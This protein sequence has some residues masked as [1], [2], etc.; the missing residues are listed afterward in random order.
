[1]TPRRDGAQAVTRPDGSGGGP[2]AGVARGPLAGVR[3]I[4]L[5]GIG[6]GPFAASILGD[7]GADVVRIDRPEGS[8][9][10]VPEEADAL[11]RSRRSI[12]LD[13]RLSAGVEVLLTMVEAADVLIEGY[14]PGVAERLGFGPDVCGARNARLVYGRMTGWGQNGPLAQTAGHDI[15]YVALTGALHA[16][17][18]DGEGPAIPLNLVGDFG[19]GSLYLAVGILSALLERE[20]S[21]VGQVVD[22]AIVDG[23]AHLTTLFHGLMAAELWQDRRGVNMLDS[24]VPWYDVY[25]TSDGRHIAVGA[26]EPAFYTELMRTLGLDPDPQRRIDPA[27]WPVIRTELTDAFAGGSLEVWTDAFAGTDACVAPVLSFA[28][29]IETPHLRERGVFVDVG[30]V[31]MPAPA[32]RFSRTPGAIQ[33]PPAPFAADTRAVLAEYGVPNIEELVEEGIV[34]EQ[35]R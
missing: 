23:V 31:A 10:G 34:L 26:V 30:G 33:S 29:A 21:G 14:R 20:R 13:L 6:P 35:R 24:G 22:A 28:E 17:G 32:P 3:V 8:A 11:R 4:E 27:Q 9:T 25:R 18:R 16:M 7:L 1:M 15:N 5:S 2:G 12:A 19:G